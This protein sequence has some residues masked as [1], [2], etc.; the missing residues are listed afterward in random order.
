MTVLAIVGPTATGKSA[1]AI[2]VARLLADHGGAEVVN[3]DSMQFYR[4]MDIGTAKLA[5]AQREGVPHHQLDTLDVHEDASA[6]RYQ[7]EGRRDIESIAARGAVPVVVGGSGL[8]VRAL[9]DQFDFPGTD[10]EVRARL[11]ARAAQEGPGILHRELAAKDPEAAAK[12]S[13]QNSK[14]I[15]RALEILEIDGA[16]ASSLPRHTYA[17]DAVQIALD[18][19]LPELDSRIAKRVDSMWADGLVDEVRELTERGLRDGVTAQRA[20]GYAET[21]RHIDGELDAAHTIELIARNTRRLARRQRR[22]FAP[23]PR[24]VWVDAPRDEADV[25]R[26]ARD[27]LQTWRDARVR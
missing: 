8:Y 10:P 22:W 13:P 3:A 19:S 1:V 21:L 2:A 23:D 20:V 7:E 15:V 27:V 11:E 25:A 6:A 5:E 17:V 12:I 16:Y 9:L 14:R 24:V 18:A 26:A 4:G